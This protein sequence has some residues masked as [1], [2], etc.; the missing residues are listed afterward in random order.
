M[1][2]N[3]LLLLEAMDYLVGLIPQDFFIYFSLDFKDLFAREKFSIKRVI[4]RCLSLVL[5]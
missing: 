1:E 5:D 4:F 3:P 2:I